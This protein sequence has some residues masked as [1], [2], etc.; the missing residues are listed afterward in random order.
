M[1]LGDALAA[2]ALELQGHGEELDGLA[3][4]SL[5]AA[6]QVEALLDPDEQER[7]VWAEPG[8]VAWAPVDVSAELRERL[9]E[10]GP[11]AILVS[12]TLTA[13]EDARFVRRRLGLDR[14]P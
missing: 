7:V 8:A 3:R 1:V 14:G 12:A 5:L 13:G 10:D 6:A 9:W 2:L 11:T 4:R